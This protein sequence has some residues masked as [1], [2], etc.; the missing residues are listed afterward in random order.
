MKRQIDNAIL[1]FAA[2][3]GIVSG[4]IFLYFQI[5]HVNPA[6]VGFTLLLAVLVIS[7][8]WGL[9]HAIFAAFVATVAY[10]YFFLPPVFRLTIADPQN[11][12]ALFAFLVTAIV[13]S[14]LAERARRGTQH[15]DQR[16]REV[17]RL[18]S[19]SQQLWLSDNVFE[20][21]NI[22]PKHIVDSFG[23]TGTALFLEGK[24]ETY[25]LDQASRALFPVDQLKSINDRG[26]PVFDRENKI[27]YMPLRMGVRSVGAL[28]LAGCDLSR[29]SLEAV[30]SLIAISIER[31]NT[32]E[33]LSRS[34][35]AR[36]SDRLR[37]VLLD[38]VT[39][40]FRTPLTAIKAAAETLLSDVELDKPQRK[41]LLQVID[42]ESD[43][44]DRLV[45]EAGEVAQ[46][47]SHQVQLHMEPHQIKEAI[48][49]AISSSQQT[50]KQHP[51]T[52]TIPENLPDLS[53]DLE[54]ISEV[55][56]HLLDNAGKYSS[57]GTPIC[58]T[59]E[60]R[61]AEVIT[62]VADHGPGIDE[63]EQA[64]IFEKFYRGRNQRMIIHGTGMGLPIAKAIVELHGGK[65][66]V[67]S[68]LGRGSLF[69]FSLPAT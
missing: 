52:V 58:V 16:R 38:S 17:E 46:L 28:G 20:L 49:H 33:K 39:H 1:R 23:V 7:A 47:D 55:I 62:S 26:E 40:E 61:D 25:F 43:R 14:Q 5:I 8:A 37:S 68:Q 66:G 13:G 57:P 19:F 42:E 27:C 22:I 31:A 45:G 15:A 18:Y 48:D 60:L 35:A 63:M 59:S 32:V 65:I 44:L 21:L 24:E 2:S 30:G 41:D 9:R 64:M 34:E 11:W 54:R 50:L 69:Y 29:E 4:I 3:I 56:V 36:E 12:I 51:V 6:T 10:N 53:M 67:T